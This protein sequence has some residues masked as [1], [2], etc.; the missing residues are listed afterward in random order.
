MTFASAFGQEPAAGGRIPP[1]QAP[2]QF[3]KL[4]TF[5]SI[6]GPNGAILLFHR[7]ADW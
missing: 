7:S 6:R 1:F 5:D 3:G 2:D 4:Q